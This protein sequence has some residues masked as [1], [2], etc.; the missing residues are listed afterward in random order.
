M[1]TPRRWLWCTVNIHCASPTYR[2]RS[3]S[4]ACPLRGVKYSDKFRGWIDRHY[5]AGEVPGG[6]G[7]QP[8]DELKQA[9]LE[10]APKNCFG[11]EGP[12][13]GS[14]RTFNTNIYA[15]LSPW[16]RNRK[17]FHII[18]IFIPWNS[19]L[20]IFGLEV[21][22]FSPSPQRTD[23]SQI[24]V[25]LCIIHQPPIRD[26]RRRQAEV[27]ILS[28]DMLKHHLVL[29]LPFFVSKTVHK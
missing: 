18:Y 6:D 14:L 13:G 26:L 21:V 29:A 9:A 10:S 24:L 25:A 4:T 20:A 1:S 7:N 27:H 23:K 5:V 17:P 11:R 28:L 3:I 8:S 12:V 19:L 15:L 16:I 2:C 22:F